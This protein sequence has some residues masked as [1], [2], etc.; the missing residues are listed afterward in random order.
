MHSLKSYNTFN[1]NSTCNDIV[2]FHNLD[3]LKKSLQMYGSDTKVLGGGS[4]VLMITPHF[5]SILI[6]QI[7]GINI[8]DENEDYCVVEVGAGENWHH[9]VMWSV[10]HN[11][12]GLEN[13]AYIPGT[14]G[15]APIQNIGAYGIEQKDSFVSCQALNRKGFFYDCV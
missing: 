14:V 12:G 10:Y 7:K 3:S 11:L 8:I 6:N 1:I 5:T 15:A 13:M 9:F 2:P 4:N